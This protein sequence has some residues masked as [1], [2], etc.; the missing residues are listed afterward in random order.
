ML[1]FALAFLTSAW[2]HPPRAA[3]P[4]P[5]PLGRSVEG[6]QKND[7]TEM[8][9]KDEQRNCENGLNK[10]SFY[11]FEGQFFEGSVFTRTS[12]SRLDGRGGKMKEKLLISALLR[13]DGEPLPSH[14][15]QG[16]F[17]EQ[18]SPTVASRDPFSITPSPAQPSVVCGGAGESIPGVSSGSSRVCAHPQRD[19][20]PPVGKSKVAGCPRAPVFRLSKRR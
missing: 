2:K 7:A 8:L 10:K 3:L 6:F 20:K 17:S 18:F 12:A 11:Q 5:P 15:H 13:P 9:L 14:A 1:G 16:T 19:Q 4:P